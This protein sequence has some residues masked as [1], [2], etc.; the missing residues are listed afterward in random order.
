M[1]CLIGV[2]VEINSRTTYREEVGEFVYEEC[3]FSKA[4]KHV[5]TPYVRVMLTLPGT[6][7][8]VWVTGEPSQ[9]LRDCDHTD[10]ATLETKFWELILVYLNTPGQSLRVRS[11]VK[12]LTQWSHFHGA[13]EIQDTVAQAL[14][15]QRDR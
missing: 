8:S 10:L 12:D 5:E 7:L 14:G 4:Y 15:L 6:T 13:R 3:F 9:A 11:L 2:P 1:I